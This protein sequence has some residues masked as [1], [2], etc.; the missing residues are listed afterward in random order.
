MFLDALTFLLEHQEKVGRPVVYKANEV[1]GRYRF[2]WTEPA[3]AR[4][5]RYKNDKH[6][7]SGSMTTAGLSSLIICQNALWKARAFNG[8]MRKRTRDGIRDAM[9]WMQAFYDVTRNPVEPAKSGGNGLKWHYYYLYGLER[10]GVLGR[11]R[12][13][14]DNDWYFDG[15]LCLLDHQDVYWL[16][17]RSL[18]DSCFAVLFLKRATTN[19]NAPVITPRATEPGKSAK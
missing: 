6:P 7:I 19:V 1:R 13:F 9:A 16:I 8:K 11:I 18:E 10:A 5:F 3:V 17:P 12:H 2:E 4:G 15:A 14:G